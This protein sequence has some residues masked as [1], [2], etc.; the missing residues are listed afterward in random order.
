M[1]RAPAGLRCKISQASC[2]DLK[3]HDSESTVTIIVMNYMCSLLADNRACKL[4]N[5]SSLFIAA[6]PRTTQPYRHV[7]RQLPSTEEISIKHL[8][9]R[10]TNI[11]LGDLTH[12]ACSASGQLITEFPHHHAHVTVRFTSTCHSV[13]DIMVPVVLSA[14]LLHFCAVSVADGADKK[15]FQ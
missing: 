2:R 6:A 11:V 3:S 8:C 13:C 15:R 14:M 5:L 7:S 9:H 4:C 1:E 12:V 10:R